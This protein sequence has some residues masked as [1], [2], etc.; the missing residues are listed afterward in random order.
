MVA[1]E[2]MWCHMG[3]KKNV[4]S[5]GMMM[6]SCGLEL[7]RIWRWGPLRRVPRALTIKF[8]LPFCV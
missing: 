8:F 1:K 4:L 2:I 5:K 3:E 7:V 6:R